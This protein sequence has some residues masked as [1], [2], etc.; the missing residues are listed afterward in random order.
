MKIYFLG[1]EEVPLNARGAILDH[2]DILKTDISQKVSGNAPDLYIETHPLAHDPA[3]K[4]PALS[5]KILAFKSDKEQKRHHH[6]NPQRR[7]NKRLFS[8]LN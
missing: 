7:P 4:S 2:A 3:Q 5:D 6:S 8:F 1:P